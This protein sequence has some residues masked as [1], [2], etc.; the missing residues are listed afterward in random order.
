MVS[1]TVDPHPLAGRNPFRLGHLHEPLVYLLDRLRPDRHS[2]PAH[3]LGI[4]HLAGADP[5]EVTVDQV[6]AHFALQHRVAP[7]ADMLEDEKTQDHLGRVTTPTSAQASRVASAERFVNRRDNGLIV[8]QAI[9]VIH[10]ALAQVFHFLG[11]Q[12][13]AEA[14]LGSPH[15]NHD[16]SPVTVTMPSPA[17]AVRD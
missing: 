16:A 5:S 12:A 6:G 3:R 17:A 11:D 10:P 8:E 7:I 15:L 9:G 4:R 1:T 2:P 14:A 13:V